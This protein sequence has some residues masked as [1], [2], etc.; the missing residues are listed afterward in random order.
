MGAGI[1]RLLRHIWYVIRYQRLD[2]DL[3]EELEFH[4]AMKQ[5]EFGRQGHLPADAVVATRRS[6]GSIALAQDRA[7]DVWC[8]R[9]LQGLGQDCRLAVRKLLATKLVTTVAVLSLALGI[10]ANTA[11]FSFVSSLLL[12]PLPIAAPE[13]LVTVSSATAVHEGFPADW[14]YDVWQQIHQRTGLFEGTVAWS[15]SRFNLASGGEARLVDG[16]WVNGLFFSTLAVRP[17]LG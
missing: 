1:R 2:D 12:R 6:M 11:I 5:R 9:W 3:A 16:L 7:R 15:R 10:G 17:I 14:T 8:P 4:R 13:R